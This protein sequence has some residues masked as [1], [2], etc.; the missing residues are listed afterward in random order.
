MKVDGSD[1]A[2]PHLTLIYDGACPLCAAEIAFL[3]ARDRAG[4]LAFVDAAA[5]PADAVVS[6]VPR[7]DALAAM[8]AIGGDGSVL[9]GVAVFRAAY[10]AVGLHGV[11][12]VISLP[13]VAGLLDRLY[14]WFARHRQ[15]V[16]RWLPPLLFSTGRAGHGCRDG[17][18][19][20]D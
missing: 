20:I 7:A 10:A 17:V 12:K 1:A 13:L 4:R 6:G 3:R 11:V 18:C 8:T 5:L 15:W 19:R 16:P 9:R 2:V 14:P